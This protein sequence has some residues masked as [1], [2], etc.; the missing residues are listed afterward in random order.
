MKVFLIITGKYAN[1]TVGPAFDTQ[2][3]AEAY[4]ERRE[5]KPLQT[6]GPT[7]PH[8]II[9]LD[10]YQSADAAIDSEAT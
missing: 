7:G 3:A 5:V 9:E 4:I 1:I 6:L 10:V 2:A 8:E